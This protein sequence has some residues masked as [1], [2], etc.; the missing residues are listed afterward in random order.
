MKRY[1]L[2]HV[3]FERPTP[4]IMAAWKSWFDTTAP[5]IIEN[6]GLRNGSEITR[7]GTK[8]LVMDLDALTG[9][10]IVSAGSLE[11]AQQLAASNPFVSSIRVY[12]MMTQQS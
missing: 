5:Q 4:E 6:I 10:T 11:E 12:E 7:D 8:S 2:L 1:M 9:F 3:G